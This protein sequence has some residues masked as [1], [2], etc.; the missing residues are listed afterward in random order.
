MANVLKGFQ[1]RF[2]QISLSQRLILGLVLVVVAVIIFSGVPADIALWLQLERQIEL[3]VEDS[4]TATH[5]LYEAEVNRL[6]KLSGLIAGRPTLAR[7]LQERDLAALEPYLDTLQAESANV[8]VLQ[9]ITPDLQAGDALDGLPDPET[10]LAGNE[11]YFADLVLLDQ[12]RRLYILAI[13]QLQL[14]QEEEPLDGWVILARRLGSDFMRSLEEETGLAQSL[15]VGGM[16]IATS[17]PSAPPGAFDQDSVVLV[18][19]TCEPCLT[20]G[21][22]Q[23]EHYYVGLMPLNDS[24]G[25]VV[26]LSEVALAIDNI[27]RDMLGTIAFSAA[28]SL[29]VMLVGAILIIRQARMITDPLSQLSQAAEQISQGDLDVS[30]A[31]DTRL[32]EIDQLAQHF[33]LARRQL[34]QMLAVTQRDMKHAERLLSSVRQGVVALDEQGRITFFNPDA[35]EILGYRAENVVHHHYS[36]IFP[37]APGEVMGMKDILDQP[38]GDLAA[39]RV[40]IL[41][42]K[43]RPLL[44]AVHVSIIEEDLPEGHESERV[45]VIRDVTEEEAVN[46]LRYNF[47]AN[48]AHEFRTPLS[49]IAA[50]AELL[51]DDGSYLSHDDLDKLVGTIRISTLHLQT[52]VDN[53]LESTTIEAGCF[54]VHRRP[55]DILDIIQNTR[56]IML[57]LLERR[58]QILDITTPSELPTLW[59]DANRLTQVL[60]NLLSNAS[61]FSP[62]GGQIDLV[63]SQDPRWLK[64]AVLDCGSGLPAGLYSDLF[65]RFVTSNQPHETRYGIG[66][67]LSVVKSIVELHGG[68]VG[69]ENRPEGGAKVWFTIPIQPPEEK[70]S[71]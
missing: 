25:K 18:E 13:S 68:Q 27:R 3:R 35:E 47:L 4:Q 64:I 54:K 52:L 60:V 20:Q 34:R 62:M 40:C 6:K 28:I 51:A 11:P 33:D 8:D 45:L 2:R 10:F 31:I 48:V 15:I 65:K 16:R 50:T 66:L 49:G 55:I 36:R 70:E 41:D 46:R 32:P 14:S 22:N 24:Q 19:S 5:A 44:L 7:L 59:A 21:S 1:Q 58:E 9:V 37:L 26:A 61:K 69:A 38:P 43:A 30:T 56:E 63:L 53:L 42:A 29:V 17:L 67:G 39:Q 23:S 12:P 57:P 71:S